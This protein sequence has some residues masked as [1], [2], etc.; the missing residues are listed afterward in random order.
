MPEYQ[1]QGYYHGHGRLSQ[2]HWRGD[3]SAAEDLV[4]WGGGLLMELLLSELAVRMRRTVVSNITSQ[5]LDFLFS[6][7]GT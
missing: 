3:S 6:K 7:M 2:A 5:S 4:G 1:L